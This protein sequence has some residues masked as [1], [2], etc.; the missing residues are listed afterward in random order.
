MLLGQRFEEI[1]VYAGFAE[2]TGVLF[3]R[4][5]YVHVYV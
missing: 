3:E 4:T 2:R 5:L 1:R